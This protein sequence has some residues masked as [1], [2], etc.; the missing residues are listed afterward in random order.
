MRSSSSC[1]SLASAAASSL[2]WEMKVKNFLLGVSS[3]DVEEEYE[4]EEGPTGRLW[5]QPMLKSGL[6]VEASLKRFWKRMKLITTDRR[7]VATKCIAA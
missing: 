5:E 4:E 7:L 3:P 1:K 2:K 6:R